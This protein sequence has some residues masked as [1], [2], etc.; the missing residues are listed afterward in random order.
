MRGDPASFCK[1]L[2]VERHQRAKLFEL[3]AATSPGRLWRDQGKSTEARDLLS[4]IYGR[5]TEGFDTPVLQEA[6]ALLGEP[7]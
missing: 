1:A 4:P 6:K 2:K 5:F 3:G 7:S